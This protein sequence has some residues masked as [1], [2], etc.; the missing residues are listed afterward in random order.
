MFTFAPA[1]KPGVDMPVPP[2]ATERGSVRLLLPRGIHV[3]EDVH[4]WRLFPAVAELLKKSCPTEQVDG[5][6]A[7]TETGRVTGIEEKSGLRA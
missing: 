4:A 5:S 2:F 1:I 6:E 7:P 3:L